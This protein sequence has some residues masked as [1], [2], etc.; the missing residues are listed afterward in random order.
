MEAWLAAHPILTMLLIGAVGALV[1]WITYKRTPEEWK[2]YEAAHP[3]RAALV[4]IMRVVFPH[5][6]KIPA[7]AMFLP[8]PDPPTTAMLALAC[9]VSL[10]ACAVPFEEARLAGRTA[11]APPGATQV[12]SAPVRDDARCRELDDGRAW[13]GAAAKALGAAGGA[14][15]LASLPV[16]DAR[17]KTGLIIG[18]G[19]AAALAAG[20][21]M[22]EQSKG[23]A[24]A[25]ECSQ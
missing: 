25:R 11:A 21:V 8:P 16:D 22:L 9:I 5:L 15:G 17:T 18:G 14:S 6:R 12:A 2:A 3:R 4:R 1:N 13:Y 23:A 10:S 20:A 19:V 7:I 24:W